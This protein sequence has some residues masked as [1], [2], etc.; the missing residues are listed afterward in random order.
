MPASNVPGISIRDA[1]AA[2]LPRILELVAQLSLDAPR[3][4]LG[5]PVPEH[6]RAA[7]QAIE[8]DPRQRLLVLEANG[9]IAGTLV[10]VVVPNLSH[11][12]RPYALV[13]DVVVDEAER[14][15]GYGE[16]L[17]RYAMDAARSAGCYK[18]VLTSNKRRAD[19]HRFYKRLGLEAT[20]EGFRFDFV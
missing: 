2:D 9:R 13:E 20:S 1:T 17:M 7:F 15:A 8:A 4:E 18:L 16:L 5:P 10:L 3:E 14:G 12:G 6:Y 19:A 11:Q